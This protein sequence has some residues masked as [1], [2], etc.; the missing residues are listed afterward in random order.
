MHVLM[1][2]EFWVLKATM[3]SQKRRLEQNVKKLKENAE[4]T[5]TT[6]PLKHFEEN[7]KQ[8]FSVS[9]FGVI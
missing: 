8:L 2:C 4:F 5:P 1:Q 9:Q 6:E 7:V 3:S